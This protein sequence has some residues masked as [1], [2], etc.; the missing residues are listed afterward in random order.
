MPEIIDVVEALLFASDTPVEASRIQEVL[1]LESPTVA[2]E[3]VESL[4][5]PAGRGRARPAG[6]GGGRRLPSRD[7]PGDRARGS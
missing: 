6:D 2:R 5:A 3:L 1:D 7:A 4:R